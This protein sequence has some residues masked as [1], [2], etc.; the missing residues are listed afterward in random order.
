MLALRRHV[1]LGMLRAGVTP[2][3]YTFNIVSEDTYVGK[4]FYCTCKFNGEQ[5]FGTWSMGLGNQYAS[6][7]A[8]GKV[9]INS[10]VQN[11][12]IIVNCT[13]GGYS[14]SKTITISYDNQL[15]IE[16]AAEISGTSGNAVA[17]YNSDVV[18]PTWS[19][20]S[21]NQY[22]T[23]N[24]NGEITILSSGTIVIQAVYSSYTTTKTVSV[25]YVIGQSS[26][27]EIGDDGSVT[28]TT[29]TIVENQDGSTT[30]TST[31]T[32][33][34]D[35]GSVSNTETETT[36]NQDGSS[37]SSSTTVNSDG[38]SSQSDTN[39]ASDGSS[40]NVTTNYDE[41]GDPTSGSSNTTDVQGNSNT[42]EVVYDEN[43]DTEVVGYT[44]DTSGNESGSG[45][46]LT[47]NGV[48]TEF[49]PFSNAG[50]EGFEMHIV[51]RT[52]KTE[53]PNPP[54][55]VDTEDTGSNYLFN[56]MTCKSPN[57]PYRGF[58]IRWALSKKNYSSGNLVL[59]YTAANASSTTS[60]TMYGVNDIYDITITYDPLLVKYPSKFRCVSNQGQFSTVSTNIT[61][62]SNQLDFVLGYA[63]NQQGNPYRYSNVTIYEFSVVRL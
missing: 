3:T 25:A 32:T 43:G 19:I 17:M 54:I 2:V 24:S 58:H 30:E 41:N 48:N 34:H 21:G 53:Q 57:K 6:I 9:T 4:F 61:F 22:A 52:V 27:T 23:I 62:E 12:N 39:V 51:F 56:I 40:T 47:G 18:T 7:N 50:S 13:Y 44:I 29:T 42:Q 15:A 20:T 35:D 37:T 16:C 59:G 10:G 28:T 60:R 46:E 38:T 49:V 45:E 63:V 55:V 33:T 11:Q 31:S 5:V 26:S 14:D 8:N 36:T 1:L